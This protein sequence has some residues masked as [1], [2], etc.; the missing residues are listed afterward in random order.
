M[1]NQLPN[2]AHLVAIVVT[3]AVVLGCVLL[4]YE[5]LRSYTGL[6]LRITIRTRPRIM[7]LILGILVLHAAE[8][9]IF[10]LAYYLLTQNPDHGALIAATDLIDVATL[11]LLDYVYYSAA[12]Y[13]TL[14]FGDLVPLGPIRYLTGAE[15]VSGLVLI[16]WSASFTFLEMQRFW[17]N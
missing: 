4:H 1:E 16:T 10:G 2:A 8:I 15:A 11:Q 7:V 5:V 6:L 17:K 3:T 14:G 9:W 12:V 13:T